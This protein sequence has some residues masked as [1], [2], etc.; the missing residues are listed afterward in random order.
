LHKRTPFSIVE[1]PFAGIPRGSVIMGRS[2]QYGFIDK[3]TWRAVVLPTIGEPGDRLQATPPTSGVSGD[4]SMSPESGYPLVRVR[5]F[6]SAALQ[7]AF[8][9]RFCIFFPC[10]FV[11]Q[12]GQ[13]ECVSATVSD[14]VSVSW[15][16]CRIHLKSDEQGNVRWDP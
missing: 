6:Q 5:H 15:P 7:V 16:S 1:V 10:L 4:T 8:R 13:P 14:D 3:D 2:A 11:H 9:E 12:V